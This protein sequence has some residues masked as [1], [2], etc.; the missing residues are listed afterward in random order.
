[1]S[2]CGGTETTVSDD[3]KRLHPVSLLVNL[4]PRTLRFARAFWP[5]VLVMIFVLFLSIIMI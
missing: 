4:V 1:M 5:I 3:W 2:L